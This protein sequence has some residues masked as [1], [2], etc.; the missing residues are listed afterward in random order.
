MAANEDRKEAPFPKLV[1]AAEKPSLLQFGPFTLDLQRH[2][3]Y[4]DGKRVHLTSKPFETLAVLVEHRGK[5]VEKQKLLDAVWKEAFVTEDSLVK[6]VREIRRVLGDEKGSPQFIQT[7]P[8]EG[9]RFIAEVTPAKPPLQVKDPNVTQETV[10][11]AAP[12]T[13]QPRVRFWM[14]ATVLGLLATLAAALLLSPWRKPES[15]TQRAILTLSGLRP[16]ASFSPDGNW[17]TFTRDDANGVPQV[18]VQNLNSGQPIPITSGDIP[19][20]R[21]RWSPK[22]DA[23]VFSRGERSQSV[24]SVPPIGGVLDPTLLIE[25]GSNPSWSSDGNQLVFEKDEEIWT[26][27]ADGTNQQR[28]DGVP[29]VEP[30]I[31]AR[32]PSFSPDGSQIAF[33][34]NGDGPMG[35]IWVIP[36]KGGIAE[37]LTFD[38]HFGGGPVWTRDGNYIVFSSQRGGSKT[39]WKLRPGGVPEPVLNSPGEDTHPEISPDGS[40]LIYTRTRNWWVLTLKDVL[41]GKTQELRES[42]TD[43]Y[44]PTF[45]RHG[46]KIA[47]FATVDGG[48]IHVFTIRVDGTEPTQVTRSK[49]ERNVFPR[50]SADGSKFYFYQLRP[51]VS[52]RQ[53]SAGGESS[54]IANGWKWR[55]HNS[56]RV[57]AD[58]KRVIFI[59]RENH[60]TTTIVREIETKGEK[61]FE[62]TLGDPQWSKDGKFVV[63]FKITPATYRSSPVGD[64]VVC[65]VD[66][67][68][69]RKVASS[70]TSPIWS[71]DESRIYF[72]RLTSRDSM[73]ILSVSANG[74]DERRV[75]ELPFIDPTANFFD[76]SSTGQVVYVQFKPGKPELWMM[77]FK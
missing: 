10:T 22:N 57:D 32:E 21:P 1:D 70:G 24:W 11:L 29:R 39:L 71:G 9:Y 48:D 58:G 37:R 63:G 56:G 5:T 43:M 52:F 53:I 3:L 17:I 45:S 76:V 60:K 44:F 68:T 66:H 75:V 7:V 30:P 51:T 50:W 16:G 46:D 27:N 36:S 69:C 54:E 26:A 15:S 61:V 64:I 14:V 72:A 12:V 8:G 40:R 73:E 2:G 4:S 31:W 28:V 74:E 49:G 19:A 55:T 23:I 77:D 42:L 20:S 13:R 18:W 67:G 62:P 65:P 33:F 34:Q 38:N 47:F 35:D 59:R 6:A 41:S 25:G